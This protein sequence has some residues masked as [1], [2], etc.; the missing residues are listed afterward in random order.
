MWNVA[1]FLLCTAV[2]LTA[3]FKS[4]RTGGGYYAGDVYG[5]TAGQHLGYAALAALFAALFLAAMFLR[6]IPSIPLLAAFTLVF[7]LYFS[8]FA[9]G[10]SDEE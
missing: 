10:F 9:R 2:I 3:L 7:I 8:S 5:M 1:G 6:V 4:K